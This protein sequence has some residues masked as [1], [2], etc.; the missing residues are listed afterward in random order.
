MSREDLEPLA[1]TLNRVFARL[2]FADP[3]LLSTLSS[4]WETL[5]PQPW[6]QRS[7]PVGVRGKTLVV[8]ASSPSMVAFL[9]YGVSDLLD[10]ISSRLG[11]GV[12]DGIDVRPPGRS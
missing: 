12:I 6:P 7:K 1:D 5:A 9:R 4:E 11:A 2:G 3:R 10:A 8:E